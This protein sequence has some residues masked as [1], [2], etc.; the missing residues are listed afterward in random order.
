MNKSFWSD[1]RVLV[2][3]CTGFLG[4]WLTTHLFNCG[5]DVIGL[6]RDQVPKSLIVQSGLINNITVVE[7]DI[8]DY[9]LVERTLAE[10]E[11][12]TIFHLAAQT[13]VTIANR[14]PLSTFE[15]NIRGTWMLLEA[16][17]RNPTVEHVV[18]ASS[19][20]AYG[21]H[22][23]LPYH[24]DMALLGSHPYDVSKSC[25][26]LLAR[27]YANTYELPLVV[28]RFANIYGGG[29]L[30]WNRIVPGSIR[31][32]LRGER[33][34][35]RSDGTPKRDYVFVQ[36]AVNGY[37]TAAEQVRNDLVRGQTFNFGLDQPVPVI[38]IVETIIAQ[39]NYPEL[40]PKI[41]DQIQ[42]EISD[43]YLDSRRA[44]EVLGWRPQFTLEQGLGQ[45][46]EWYSDFL[47]TDLPE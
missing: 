25:A 32:V 22:K 40:K 28:T 37:L 19:D 2:T 14:A 26:D 17:R 18:V 23:E 4:S 16:A 11:I 39:S 31:S 24:E 20:K 33:P 8:V 42:N 15:T 44:W 13:I 38:E 12:D 45:T 3:G 47:S 7:G 43:Q 1:R 6:V 29:D 9:H 41:L 36:D 46:M 34:V 10:Y 30:N 5:A 27:A 21:S 35:V